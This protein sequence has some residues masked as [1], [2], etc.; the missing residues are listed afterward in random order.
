MYKVYYFSV[1]L[2]TNKGEEVQVM[3]N[4]RVMAASYEE[5]KALILAH[6]KCVHQDDEEQDYGGTTTPIIVF[7]EEGPA[8]RAAILW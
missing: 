4:T 7:L 5:A 2:L 8:P 6:V 3:E 1:D